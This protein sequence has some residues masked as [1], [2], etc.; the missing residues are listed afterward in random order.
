MLSLPTRVELN[1]WYTTNEK[2]K[3]KT[4]IG[5][6]ESVLKQYPNSSNWDDTVAITAHKKINM[7]FNIKTWTIM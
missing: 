1:N 6:H 7:K 5:W 2:G 3:K 4:A